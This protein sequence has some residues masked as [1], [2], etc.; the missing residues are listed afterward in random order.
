MAQRGMNTMSEGLSSIA[1]LCAELMAY[2][3][4][5]LE[6]LADLQA[7]VI[8]KMRAGDPA[9]PNEQP[10]PMPGGG[11][12]GLPTGMGGMD[13]GGMGGQM[14]MPPPPGGMPPGGM[15]PGGGMAPGGGGGA[16]PNAGE[17][18]RIL[19]Q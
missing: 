18:Q 8:A 1:T 3:D 7:Q 6:W 11:Q 12:D 10:P 14:Q 17:L 16:M 9:I 15:P 2:P 13:M 5:D 4:A 19:S